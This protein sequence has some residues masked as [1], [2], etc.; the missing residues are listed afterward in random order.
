MVTRVGLEPTAPS[1]GGWAEVSDSRHLQ[2]DPIRY[3]GG[4]RVR[5]AVCFH[6]LFPSFLTAW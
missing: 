6:E 2:T 3:L 5:A 4:P 1:F